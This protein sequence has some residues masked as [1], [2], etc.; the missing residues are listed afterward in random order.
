MP[1][2]SEKQQRGQCDGD[3]RARVM[4]KRP[5]DA[6]SGDLKD[7]G[8]YSESK[9]KSSEDVEQKQYNLTCFQKDRCS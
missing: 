5:D 7:T 1:G 6:A 3:G 9:W 4:A 8:F 2:M